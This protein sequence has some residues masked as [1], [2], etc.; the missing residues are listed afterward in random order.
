MYSLYMKPT[1]VCLVHVCANIVN[2]ITCYYKYTH[3]AGSLRGEVSVCNLVTTN[4]C[5][6]P[7]LPSVTLSCYNS[8]TFGYMECADGISGACLHPESVSNC[9]VACLHT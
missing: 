8:R 6:L 3:G 9:K 5:F 1:Y 7:S 2:Y 4:D